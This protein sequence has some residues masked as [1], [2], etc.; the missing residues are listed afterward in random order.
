MTPFLI[1]LE[2]NFNMKKYRKPV[3]KRVKGL[4]F[5]FQPVHEGWNT[6]C[7]QCS[8]CHGCR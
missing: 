4:D 5:V 2:A 6:V 1:L 7:H 8:G 3:F